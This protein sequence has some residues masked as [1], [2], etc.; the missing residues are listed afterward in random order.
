MK[1]VFLYSLLMMIMASCTTKFAKIQKSKDHQYK[2]K[3]AEQFYAKKKYRY[4]QILFEE[5]FPFVKGTSQFEDTYYKFAYCYFYDNDFINAENLFK[6]FVE[7]FPNST[8]SEECEYMRAYCYYKQSPKVELDQ[9]NTYKTIGLMQTFINTHPTSSRIKDASNIIDLC[10]EKLE[11]KDLK[12][13]ELYYSMG[14]YKS[15]AIY[16]GLVSENYPDSKRADEYKLLVIKSYFKYA[17]MSV[18]SKQEE[19]FEKV[20]KECD[21]FFE[22]FQDSKYLAE[23]ERYKKLSNNYIKKIKNEQ[24]KKTT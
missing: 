12:S 13:A 1:K 4:A 10:R 7:T 23:S 16:Y 17:E 9:T 21:D 2:L 22:R 19:R 6:N 20:I 3:M 5:T 8:K 18:V 24:I 15:A 14:F 11:Q